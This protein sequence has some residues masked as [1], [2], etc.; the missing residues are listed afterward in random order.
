MALGLI[1]AVLPLMPTVVFLICAAFAFNRSS[2]R[3]HDWLIN[4]KVFG[5]PLN[6][7]YDKGAISRRS[8]VFATLAI[9]GSV[10]LSLIL[11]VPL[12]ALAIQVTILIAVLTFIL[13]RPEPK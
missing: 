13:S 10:A 8:K 9:S 3:F 2:P 4:H 1:G 6:D 5:P 12:W 7:W 11:S